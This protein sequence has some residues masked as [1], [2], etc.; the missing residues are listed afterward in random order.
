MRIEADTLR[1]A[2]LTDAAGLIMNYF[3]IPAVPCQLAGNTGSM[4]A[5]ATGLRTLLQPT[6]LRASPNC[7]SLLFA[8]QLES[9]TVSKTALAKGTA[10][11]H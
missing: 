7:F 8:K 10:S 4:P 11:K 6:C 2:L 3:F 1:D 9:S 5:L